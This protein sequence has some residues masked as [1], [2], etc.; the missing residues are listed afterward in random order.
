MHIYKYMLQVCIYIYIYIRI[1]IYMYTYIHIYIYI[2]DTIVYIYI[3]MYIERER[4]IH[5][6]IYI[7]I[8]N[9]MLMGLACK[10]RSCPVVPCPCL[11]SPNSVRGRLVPYTRSPLEVPVPVVWISFMYTALC[12]APLS[13]KPTNCQ[14][15]SNPTKSN[16]YS[17]SPLQD[18]R[19]FGPRPWKILAATN[20]KNDF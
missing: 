14:S 16:T 10:R 8:Y 1:Y 7:Y 9:C 2:Y 19:L 13:C 17:R 12:Q 15:S 3:Y 5:T 4:Y 20:E 11:R 18:S 6:N